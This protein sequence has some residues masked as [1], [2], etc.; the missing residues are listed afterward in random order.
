MI[1]PRRSDSAAD[2][3][4]VTGL[5]GGVALLHQLRALLAELAADGALGDAGEP[6]DA[7]H[8]DVVD[9]VLGLAA[10]AGEIERRLPGGPARVDPAE[11]REPI[12]LLVKE[13]L[14]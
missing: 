10:L 4:L 6:G 5:L 14:R 3:T 2:P 11:P 13:L 8:P 9:V 7:A 12:N 1:P